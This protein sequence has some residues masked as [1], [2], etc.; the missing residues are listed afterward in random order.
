MA[1]RYACFLS[2]RH[3]DSELGRRAVNDFE[4]ALK[5]ELGL[6]LNI[7]DL[8]PIYR[9]ERNQPGYLYNEVIAE[10]L[11]QS[12]CMA[13]IYWPQY[14]SYESRYCT[15]EYRAMVALEEKRL[16]LLPNAEHKLGL[17]IPIMIR[18]RKEDLPSELRDK[19]QFAEFSALSLSDKPMSRHKKFQPQVRAIAEYIDDRCRAFN[20]V[21]N[22]PC[23][24][25]G[26]FA[27]PKEDEVK[28]WLD[29]LLKPPP[30]VLSATGS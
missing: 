14:F 7:P 29:A 23:S 13:M 1:F 21:A 18:G 5:N 4:Q 2:Y 17:I 28:A 24:G 9:D 20:A 27:L 22:D 3:S 16:A 30:Y 26:G 8:Q 15:R 11:C 19:R 10:A 25:C 6:L 12:V